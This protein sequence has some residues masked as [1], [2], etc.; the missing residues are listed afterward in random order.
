MD[1]TPPFFCWFCGEKI[2]QY[3]D[4]HH[5][6]GRDGDYYLAKENLVHAHRI[7]H[8]DYHYATIEQLLKTSW[9]VNW[10]NRITEQE[11]ITRELNKFS[12]N[13]LN[14]KDYGIRHNI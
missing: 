3:P 11:I 12:K 6:L 4:H 1:A 7:C 14:P 9:Y 10:L 2:T 5:I 13:N 8:K